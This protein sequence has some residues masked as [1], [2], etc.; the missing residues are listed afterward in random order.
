MVA[1]REFDRNVYWAFVD[2]PPGGSRNIEL[3]LGGA[4]DLS[5]GEYSFDWFSQVLANPERLDWSLHV[6][7]GGRVAGVTATPN[8]PVARKGGDAQALWEA[9]PVVWHATVRLER[10]G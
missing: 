9:A 3:Q 1:E 7:G 6:E 4:V 5:A 8:L 2:V 10:G